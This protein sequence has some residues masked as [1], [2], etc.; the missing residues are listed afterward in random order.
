MVEQL[1]I[2]C[3]TLVECSDTLTHGSSLVENSMPPFLEN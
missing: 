2:Y 1:V 3:S